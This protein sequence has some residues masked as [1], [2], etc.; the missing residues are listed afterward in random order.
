MIRELACIYQPTNNMTRGCSS[1]LPTMINGE[2]LVSKGMLWGILHRSL[3]P[4]SILEERV[5]R[6][7][8]NSSS[9]IKKFIAHCMQS[10]KA[11]LGT[12]TR[13][14]CTVSFSDLS[15]ERIQVSH[16]LN[17]PFLQPIRY[18]DT[19]HL[20]H[21]TINKTEHYLGCSIA[22]YLS[23]AFLLI[24]GTSSIASIATK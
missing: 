17:S 6:H 15:L 3:V 8:T 18:D 2:C 7:S 24:P 11:L 5:R 1:S 20:Q 16:F 19:L 12:T 14:Q 13:V 9:F 23:Q 22:S 21:S 4:R 10:H